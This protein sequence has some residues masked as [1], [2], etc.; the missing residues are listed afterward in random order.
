MIEQSGSFGN[1]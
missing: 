1:D